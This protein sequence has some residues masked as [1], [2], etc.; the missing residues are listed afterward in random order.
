MTTV[1][2]EDLLKLSKHSQREWH[3]NHDLLPF[4][5]Q[6]RECGK[7]RASPPSS[8]LRAMVS[9]WEEQATSISDLPHTEI[10]TAE[11][12]FETSASKDF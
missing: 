7:Q 10:H 3:R 11:D 9:L 2:K 5:S 4:P 8:Q 12:K 6:I 1:I